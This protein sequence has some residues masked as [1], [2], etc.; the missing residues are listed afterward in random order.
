MKR[1]ALFLPIVI[2][3]T[4]CGSTSTETSATSQLEIKSACDFV[5]KSLNDEE[6]I[7]DD[8]SQAKA[9]SNS[10]IAKDDPAYAEA[11][12]EY[13]SLGYAILDGDNW[14]QRALRMV[15]MYEKASKMVNEDIAFSDTLKDSGFV[16][17]K[18]LVVYK[19]EPGSLKRKLS[20]EQ[21]DLDT[22]EGN[23]NRPIIREACG[24]SKFLL[25]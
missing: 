18:R 22:R 4:S 20:D 23:I 24:I 10:R 6:V 11:L 25:P 15:S 17:A 1:I 9:E 21:I 16:W 19:T 13:P 7:L 3:L 14:E 8:Q 12:A 5:L 2:L